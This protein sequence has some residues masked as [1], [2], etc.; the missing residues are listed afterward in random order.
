MEAELHKI[1]DGVVSLMLQLPFLP[2]KGPPYPLYRRLGRPHTHF[3][4]EGKKN[5]TATTGNRRWAIQFIA[6]HFSD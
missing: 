6:Y 1:L 4:C 3:G 5:S 2:G